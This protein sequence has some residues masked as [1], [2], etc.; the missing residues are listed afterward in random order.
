MLYLVLLSLR[1]QRCAQ[2]QPAGEW[3]CFSNNK[4]SPSNT[5]YTNN[6]CKSL[7]VSIFFVFLV[8]KIARF[9]VTHPRMLKKT[10]AT[11]QALYIVHANNSTKVL[12]NTPALLSFF[13]PSPSYCTSLSYSLFLKKSK[14][15]QSSYRRAFVPSLFSILFV[16]TFYRAKKE[17]PRNTPSKIS[18]IRN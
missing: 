4:S 18:K 3:G 6:S 10:F 14:R 13:S 8:W 9:R 11:L 17:E 5:L 16:L 1:D 7:F 2:R 15:R 12:K